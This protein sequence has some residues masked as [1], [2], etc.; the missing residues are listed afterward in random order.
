MYLSKCYLLHL[1]QFS[2]GNWV[3]S[4]LLAPLHVSSSLLQWSAFLSI[5]FLNSFSIFITTKGLTDWRGLSHCLLFQGMSLDLLTGSPLL[6]HFTYMSLILWLQQ[7]QL[8]TVVVKACFYVGAS[9]CSLCKSNIF[10]ARVGFSIDGC[11]VFPQCKL[12]IIPL[13]VGDW[14]CGIQNLQWMLSR[15]L[16]LLCACHSPLR[17]GLLPGCWSSSH[18][19]HFWAAVWGR[20]NWSTPVG[21]GATDYSSTGAV[22]WEAHSVM[23]P[24]THSLCL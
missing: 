8:S 10:V 21:R 24:I 11:H 3:V 16:F 15:N 5:V 23:L 17:Q 1:A 9:L 14:C 7:K 20:W 19:I 4:F 18:H 2:S 12:A 6:L 22:H 13:T